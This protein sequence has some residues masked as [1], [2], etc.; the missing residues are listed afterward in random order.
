MI[1][2][3]AAHSMKAELYSAFRASRMKKVEFGR[4]LGIPIA[5]VDRLFDLANRTSLPQIEAAFAVLGKR[6]AV[7]VQDA[8]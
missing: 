2:L 3:P 1:P 7:E 6:L 5:A 4:R 8:A